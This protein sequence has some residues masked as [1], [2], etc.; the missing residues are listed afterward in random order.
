MLKIHFLKSFKTHS[1]FGS[2][3]TIIGNNDKPIHRHHQHP[4]LQIFPS[5]SSYISEFLSGRYVTEYLVEI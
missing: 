4:L 1:Y 2:N 5:K 3:W